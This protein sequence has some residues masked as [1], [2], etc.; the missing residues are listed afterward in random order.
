MESLE[1]KVY[2]SAAV[3]AGEAA[4]I[5]RADDPRL[6]AGLRDGVGVPCLVTGDFALFD[7]GL[8]LLRVAE[9]WGDAANAEGGRIAPGS[10]GP[11][12]A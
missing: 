12:R 11:R 1:L 8:T 6:P 7:G 9:L 10:A 5:F 4:F 2:E 3:P